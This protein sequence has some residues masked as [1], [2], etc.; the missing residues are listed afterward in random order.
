V[1]AEPLRVVGCLRGRGPGFSYNKGGYARVTLNGVKYCVH[2]IV[3]QHT[4]GEAPEGRP[5]ASHLCGNPWCFEP[6]HLVWED[7]ATNITRRGCAGRVLV[8][9]AHWV[10][11]CRHVPEC[12]AVSSGTL[13]D[14]DDDVP[15]P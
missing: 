11:V 3:L 10:K 2:V 9:G 7:R 15:L 13:C 5:D 14:D 12:K 8:D 1:Y 6:T 4:A